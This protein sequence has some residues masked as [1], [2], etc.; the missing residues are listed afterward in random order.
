MKYD[1]LRKEQKP[2]ITGIIYADR[3]SHI[4]HRHEDITIIQGFPAC[5]ECG[6]ALNRIWNENR[7]NCTGCG[8]EWTSLSLVEA[9][10]REHALMSLSIRNMED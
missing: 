8:T 2:D 4:L 1:R 3:Y 10:E 5:P 9:V 7:W 6:C